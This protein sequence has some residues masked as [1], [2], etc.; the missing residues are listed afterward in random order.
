VITTSK[1]PAPVETC[2]GAAV[3]LSPDIADA[4]EFVPERHSRSPCATRLLS[5]WPS[6]RLLGR[7]G[8]APTASSRAVGRLTP[9]RSSVAVLGYARASRVRH[10]VVGWA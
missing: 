9:D 10:L 1:R 5:S 6:A 8:R 4:V 7:G 3:V 2:F